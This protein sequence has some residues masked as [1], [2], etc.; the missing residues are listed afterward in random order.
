M[1]S[2]T[3]YLA[4]PTVLAV[5]LSVVAL[6]AVACAAETVSDAGPPEW[7]AT[8][9]TAHVDRVEQFDGLVEHRPQPFALTERADPTDDVT[10][11]P[12]GIGGG[13]HRRP[14]GGAPRFA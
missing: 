6:A 3:K 8:T 14:L 12:F 9:T 4:A 11:D 5:V 7:E 2:R 1:L 13:T 10:G